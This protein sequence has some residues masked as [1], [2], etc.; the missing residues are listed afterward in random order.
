MTSG[1]YCPLDLYLPTS[2]LCFCVNYTTDYVFIN[3]YEPLSFL[4]RSNFCSVGLMNALYILKSFLCLY[5]LLNI[6][7][8]LTFSYTV[9]PVD[10]ARWGE[11]SPFQVAVSMAV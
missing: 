9:R 11:R 8:S 5:L 7:N 6:V 3:L 10:R 1:L 4:F 2:P